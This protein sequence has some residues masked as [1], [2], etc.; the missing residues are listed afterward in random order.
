MG[1]PL[2]DAIY[3]CLSSELPR[4][5]Q[6]PRCFGE[7]GLPH[8]QKIECNLCY[9][10]GKVPDDKEARRLATSIVSFLGNNNIE[11]L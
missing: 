7:G 4:I 11:E 3:M 1:M 8:K 5:Y 9:G 6:C 2:W 10:E